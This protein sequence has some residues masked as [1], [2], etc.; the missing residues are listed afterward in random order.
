MKS[1]FNGKKILL[2]S[3]RKSLQ[4]KLMKTSDQEI[5]FQKSYS[6]KDLLIV[7]IFTRDFCLHKW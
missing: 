6:M 3:P 4:G 1:H 2:D 7:M 5:D